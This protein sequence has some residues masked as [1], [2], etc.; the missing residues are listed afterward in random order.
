VAAGRFRCATL[1]TLASPV[2]VGALARPAYDLAALF[3]SSGDERYP[4]AW[5]PWLING[6]EF[7]VLYV[8][9]V[10]AAI[11]AVAYRQWSVERTARIHAEGLASL[12]RLRAL[13]AQINPHFLFNALNSLVGLNNSTVSASQDLMTELSDLLR[14]TTL[15]SEREDHTVAEELACVAT[16]L[17]IQGIRHVQLQSDIAVDSRCN[18]AL[19]PTLILTSLVENAVSHGLRGLHGSTFIEI[20]GECDGTS[21][22]LAVRNT[23]PDVV[24]PDPVLPLSMPLTNSAPTLCS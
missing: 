17:R 9:C 18:D 10:A 23:A 1:S 22:T 14:R 19:I 24:A 4:D 12:E 20:V 15:A 3:L 6:I 21:L 5:Y 11:G 8:C 16:Y 2:A 7:A 13:R